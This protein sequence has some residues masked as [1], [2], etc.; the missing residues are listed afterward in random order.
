[1]VVI[2]DDPETEQHGG[3]E[4]LV[5]DDAVVFEVLLALEF[6]GGVVGGLIEDAVDDTTEQPAS[7]QKDL[8]LSDIRP[9]TAQPNCAHRRPP[10]KNRLTAWPKLAGND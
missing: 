4:S 6:A 2:A 8:P 7:G 10:A 3:A 9:R 5:A 1:L